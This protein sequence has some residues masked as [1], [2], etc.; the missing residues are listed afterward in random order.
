[1]R[2]ARKRRRPV[3]LR[4]Q[5]RLCGIAEV[6]NR[7][8][9]IAPRG[10]TQAPYG[11]H[12]MQRHALSLRRR[13]RLA[14]HT[15]LRRSGFLLVRL[16]Q[17]VQRHLRPQLG[18]AERCRRQH[19]GRQHEPRRRGQ[20]RRPLRH[21][22]PGR[23]PRRRLQG[24]R[25]RRDRGGGRRQRRGRPVQGRA[26][27]LRRDAGVDGHDRLRRQARRP[28]H[29]SV[30]LCHQGH[31][32]HRRSVLR[33]RRSR[34]TRFPGWAGAGRHRRAAGRRRHRRGRPR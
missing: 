26:G 4:E 5:L 7:K 15:A 18:G 6:V 20:R 34:L 33:L 2:A 28:L 31:R 8:A 9:A 32:R 10:V 17:P 13:R 23:L 19:Q 27:Q 21:D 25:R 22:R 30:P 1:M 16:R 3:Q 14:R 24:Q 12:V 11:E 29:R